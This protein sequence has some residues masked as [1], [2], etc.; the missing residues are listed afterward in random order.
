VLAW[1]GNRL[2]IVTV[3][4]THLAD[5][6]VGDEP[7]VGSWRDDAMTLAGSGLP[8]LLDELSARHRRARTKARGE[9]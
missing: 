8:K 3:T 9:E 7:I 1:S 4:R 2:E 6:V 5:L